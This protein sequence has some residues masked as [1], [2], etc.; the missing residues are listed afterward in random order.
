MFP[1]NIN[2]KQT[3]LLSILQNTL[4][5]NNHNFLKNNDYTNQQ[6]IKVGTHLIKT[7]FVNSFPHI[8]ISNPTFDNGI[9]KNTITLFYYGNPNFMNKDKSN[10]QLLTNDSIVPLSDALSLL[11]EKEINLKLIR[12]HY[13]YMNSMILAQYLLKNAS[14]NTFL[15]FSEAILT[16]PS[17]SPDTYGTINEDGSYVLPSYITGIRL[18]LSGRLMTE[19]QIPRVTKKSSRISNPNVNSGSSL[20]ESGINSESM[21]NVLVDYAK[22]TS[23]NELGSFTL[24]VWI[25]SIQSIVK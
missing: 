10:N 24:K 18:E 20:N 15:H 2:F 21:N 13:P 3:K 16:Y 12:V 5:Q 1:T 17:L 7:F 6:L 8:L 4:V 22:Y 14:T 11:F 9:N 23:K 19:Q 25:S